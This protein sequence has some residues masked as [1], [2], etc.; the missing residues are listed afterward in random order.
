MAGDL[1]VD[2]LIIMRLCLAVIA[3]FAVSS[4]Y[5]ACQ[6][7]HRIISLA[8]NLTELVYTVGAGDSLIA[9]DQ[10]SDYPA[11]AKALPK[12]ANYRDLDLE[13]ILSLHPDL[14]LAWSGGN[15][16]VQ[17]D[18][19][20]KL[21]VP[22]ETFTVTRLL[23]IPAAMTRLGC[24]TGQRQVAEQK[25]KAFLSAYQEVKQQA[26]GHPT[27]SV[28]FELSHQPLMTLS[29]D[30]LI[31][32]MI[33]TCGGRNVFA[34]AWGAA[35]EISPEAV[36]QAKPQAMIGVIPGWQEAWKQWLLIPAVKSQSMFTVNPDTVLRATD[37]SLLGLTQICRDLRGS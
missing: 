6:T 29:K 32:D 30:S 20:K 33:T 7:A 12:V 18:Q 8:P 27:V 24:L 28:F 16:Q 9:T 13:K 14:V 1:G 17:L 23:D 5:A 19:L 10:A 25:T 35:P 21:G 31:D 11:A 37:R 34:N 36:I 26:A 3:C 4:L 2:R 22:V 15:P